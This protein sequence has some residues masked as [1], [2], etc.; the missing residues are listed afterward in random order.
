ML[1]RFFNSV[2][3]SAILVIL[4]SEVQILQ[5]ALKNLF[6]ENTNEVI[7]D[8]LTEEINTAN[9]ETFNTSLNSTKLDTSE[10]EIDESTKRML[11]KLDN[12]ITM[13]TK[14]NENI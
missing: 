13:Q 10:E 8:V 9:I 1:K 2:G 5:G 6:K 3:Q 4:K 12:L 11:D 14:E 7:I